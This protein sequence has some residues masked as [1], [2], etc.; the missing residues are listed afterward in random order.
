MSWKLIVPDRDTGDPDCRGSG[1]RQ[2]VENA[3]MG[4]TRPVTHVR[5]NVGHGGRPPWWAS[6]TVRRCLAPSPTPD[7]PKSFFCFLASG[8]APAIS[9]FF[10]GV[11]LFLGRLLGSSRGAMMVSEGH[12]PPHMLHFTLGSHSE[13]PA[14]CGRHEKTPSE[15]P[16]TEKHT[17]R[18][19]NK[20]G[21]VGSS[22]PRPHS[23]TPGV[24]VAR[25]DA[26]RTLLGMFAF[27]GHSVDGTSRLDSDWRSKRVQSGVA[28]AES[29]EQAITG[30]QSASDTMDSG[31]TT[32]QREDL[33]AMVS[34]TY[35]VPS[36][37]APS[38]ERREA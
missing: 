17:S 33:Q 14:A 31:S 11:S 35:S 4:E 27:L 20:N 18:R 23:T 32:P 7:R 29:T 19:P 38:T 36:P 8:L 12:G 34:G 16:H 37:R 13:N 15:G 30:R 3:T 24:P 5:R 9:A 25:S 28:Q 1:T 6:G 22:L 21:I 10:C 2:H 26:E